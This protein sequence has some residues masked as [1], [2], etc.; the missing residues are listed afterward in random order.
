MKKLML[1]AENCE[2]KLIVPAPPRPLLAVLLVVFFLLSKSP[3]HAVSNTLQL[4]LTCSRSSFTIAETLE[5]AV[6]FP[7]DTVTGILPVTLRHEDGTSLLLAVP[8]VPGSSQLVTIAAG[9]LKPGKYIL[10]AA[11]ANAVNFSIFADEHASAFWTAQWVYDGQQAPSTTLA[12]GRWMYMTS[13]LTPLA[14]R[15]PAP[16]DPTE[17]YVAAR[18]RPFARTVLAV[19]QQA[20]LDKANIWGGGHQLDMEL[21]NDWGDPW[22]QRSVVWR[23]QLSA[24]S[25]RLYP[26]AGLHVFDA[27]ALSHWRYPAIPGVSGDDTS[28]Y[29]IPHQMDEFAE[30]TGVKMPANM[31][32]AV[33]TQYYPILESWLDFMAMRQQYMEQSWNAAA[34]GA[35]SVHAAFATTN[36]QMSG[37]MPGH[38]QDGLD[39]RENRPFPIIM[40][41]DWVRTETV[42]SF[43]T[44]LTAEAFR[45]FSWEKPHYLIPGWGTPN[46]AQM[47]HAVWLPMVSK[48]E[49]IAYPPELDFGLDNARYGYYGTQTVFEIAEINR[50]LAL[51]GGVMTQ[52]PK[53]RTPVAV[54]QSSRQ[55][56]WDVARLS[57]DSLTGGHAIYV[58]VHPWLVQRCFYRCVDAGV[59]PNYLDEIEAVT[60]G[61]NFLLQWSLIYC[62][63][64]HTA[65]PAFR[66]LLTDYTAAGGKLVQYKSD[67][68][69]IPGA[70]IVDYPIG[71]GHD[72]AGEHE[73]PL[74]P[75][76]KRLLGD[77]A[78]PDNDVAYEYWSDEWAVRF[79]NDMNK[80][81]GECPYRSSNHSV[82]LGVHRAGT[83]S[84]LILAND[85]MRNAPAH[86]QFARDLTD[87]LIPAETN[88]SIPPGGV[89][90][91]L[92]NG[93]E[94]STGDGEVT[95]DLAAGDGTCLLH[96]AAPPGVPQLT[97]TPRQTASGQQLDIRLRWGTEGY[98]PFRLRLYD[99]QGTLYDERYRATTPQGDFTQFMLHYPLGA[100][101]L[102]GRWIVEV[103]EWLSGR[104][105]SKSVTV[106]SARNIEIALKT[107]D[108]VSC[109]FDDARKIG[110]LLSGNAPQPP[111]QAMNHD[112]QRVFDLDMRKF[113]IFG[114]DAPARR[115]ADVLIRHGLQAEVNPPYQIIP[116]TREA[117]RG[118]AGP[119]NGAENYE[120]IRANTIVLAGHPLAEQAIARGQINRLTN[121]LFPGEHR[122]YVQWGS[123][124]FQAGWQNIFIFGDIDTGIDWLIRQLAVD[125]NADPAQALKVTVQ[126]AP[127][128][129]PKALPALR[130]QKTIS[131]T[132]TP[133]GVAASPD[134]SIGYL[135]E[136]GG[137]VRAIRDN[138]EVLWST[139]ALLEGS[140][141]ALNADGTRLAVAGYPGL[142]VLDSQSGRLLDGYR[143]PLEGYLPAPLFRVGWNGWPNRMLSVAWNDAG[144]RVAGGWINRHGT[145]DPVL[146]DSDGKLLGTIKGITGDVT[147]VAFLPK[148]DTLLL[149]ADKLMAYDT[150]RSV[151][152]WSAPIAKARV[153]AFSAD[154]Q[155]AAA[156]GWER[157]VLL[158]NPADGTQLST[159][160]VAAVVGGIAFLP[161][162][163][164]AV[165]IWGGDH[166]LYRIRKDNP[167]PGVL[168]RA[169]NGWQ[170]VRWSPQQQALIATEQ[171]GRLWL[172]QPD[173]QARAMLNETAGTTIT[174]LHERKN[175]ILLGR[176]DRHIQWLDMP[177]EP[178]KK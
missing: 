48:L 70:I 62:P 68:L 63:G 17:A 142:L 160:S 167:Q 24:L 53:T 156:G 176:M 100:N 35:N 43:R 64:L 140:A 133:V 144:T 101:V 33:A 7:A 177:K 9:A 45:G 109:Y 31:F 104:T 137:T 158:F 143:V 178:R 1:Y 170:D 110:E 22:V 87:V 118:G 37:T 75:R 139:S 28:P 117:L 164:L 126:A 134:G 96:L 39:T 86:V 26:L 80:W 85:A 13:D 42:S 3:V 16:L 32:P 69:R 123:S 151:I 74:G 147:G 99:P 83:A 141:L 77:S 25:N 129:K 2:Q 20:K 81:I 106:Q 102:P 56:A 166:P 41:H 66:Q 131:L 148:S 44:L 79:A 128:S 89:L 54:L 132:D 47:R 115:L 103:F 124:C 10:S 95:V 91:D 27:A 145:V 65:T 11:G 94:L 149:G 120:N 154:G 30:K 121:N 168:F 92:L 36:E 72:Y 5:F 82:L 4:G 49:G 58:V 150:T 171:G 71:A 93:G 55:T 172:L 161:D 127:V 46:P 97:V 78:P 169:E 153:F 113:A 114:A 50:R 111:Y 135:L 122:A 159:T 163:S 112:S 14:P 52:L 59:V 15:P 108:P 88:I 19:N 155:L 116:F 90:Y 60:K 73:G 76:F 175:G 21:E 152:L 18:M 61:V 125:N 57:R 130:L 84:Y 107:N 98:L 38:A 157:M 165:A 8:K 138:G 105:V 23:M 51:L 6:A 67:T 40:S 173:G 146:L 12:K 34:W 174:Q 119:V 29:A 136:Y 162:N